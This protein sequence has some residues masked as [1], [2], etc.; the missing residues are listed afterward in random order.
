[1][2]SIPFNVDNNKINKRYIRAKFISEITISCD[3]NKNRLIQLIQF[4]FRNKGDFNVFGY[5]S[6]TDEYW[7]KK[8]V[9]NDIILYFTLTIKPNSYLNTDIIINQIIGKNNEMQKFVFYL[10]ETITLCKN[11]NFVKHCVSYC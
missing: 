9:K 5:N 4:S 6:K 2:F 8:I 7:A 1:M 10:D 11:S 3:I